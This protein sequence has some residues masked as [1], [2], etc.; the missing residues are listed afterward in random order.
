MIVGLQITIATYI[1]VSLFLHLQGETTLSVFFF[2]FFILH[3]FFA[4][5]KTFSCICQ[6]FLTVKLI[7]F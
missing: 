5:C 6:I 3:M 7:I 1:Y 2:F 4:I